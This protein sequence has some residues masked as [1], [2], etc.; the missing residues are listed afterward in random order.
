M[1]RKNAKD[2]EVKNLRRKNALAIASILVLIGL[3]GASCSYLLCMNDL[4]VCGFELRELKKKSEALSDEGGRLEL[5]A[6]RLDSLARIEEKMR[7]AG[8][9][10][11]DRVEYINLAP[12]SFAKR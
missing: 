11:A 1:S 6:S 12:D 9:V 5:E 7:G 2:L 10:K 8:M 4:S 3:A